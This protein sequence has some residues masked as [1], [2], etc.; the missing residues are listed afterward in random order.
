MQYLTKYRLLLLLVP[1]FIIGQTLHVERIHVKGLKKTKEAYLKKLLTQKSK[2]I[3]QEENI[4][5]DLVLLQREPAVSHARVEIDTLSTGHL[6]LTYHIEEN[7]TFI[8]AIDLWQTV[9]NAFAY[10]LGVTEY[11]VLGK[12]YTLGGF[13]RQNN[14][15][16]FGVI[17][18]NNNFLNAANE[19]KFIGQQLETL[20][21]LTV[22]DLP[23]QYR[24]QIKSVELS[25]GRDLSIQQKITLGGGWLKERYKNVS[26][27]KSEIAPERFTTRKGIV[28]LGYI[29]D[30]R[31]PY[32]YVLEGWRN[33]TYFTH[34]WGKSFTP[35]NTFYT[36]ENETTYFKRIKDS[37]NLALRLLAGVG[38]NVDSPFPP[39]AIDNNQNIRGVGNLVQ[40][41]NTFWAINSEYR[42]RLLDQNWFA[43]QANVFFDF[44]GIQ[45]VGDN[46]TALF[47]ANNNYQYAGIGLRFV[48]KYI[49][50]AVLRI[51]YGISL[52]DKKQSGIVFGIGQFF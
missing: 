19:L 33:Q 52:K 5:N 17:I 24:Y 40:R 41:G 1:Q 38:R 4:A 46:R 25:F 44:A 30:Y 10:H 48:H 49:Y 12:G 7:K 50:R 26:E 2:A 29:F 18:E 27:S 35:N 39:F 3:F 32:Y 16:G 34:V 11:N 37:G 14:Y 42:Y 45:P 51:D 23:Q 22:F 13:Y 36:L 21:P 6:E 31:I 43:C 15:P 28:K 8:P 47:S 9:N 20:E